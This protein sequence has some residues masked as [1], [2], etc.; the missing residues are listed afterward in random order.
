MLAA[1]SF[2]KRKIGRRFCP[3]EEEPRPKSF[4][5]VLSSEHSRASPARHTLCRVTGCSPSAGGGNKPYALDQLRGP[6]S[7]RPPSRAF[8]AAVFQGRTEC[9]SRAALLRRLTPLLSRR[10]VTAALR[11]FSPAHVRFGSSA[12]GRYASGGRAMS[13]APPK[14]DIRFTLRHVCL[15]PNS[16]HCRNAR[17]D[18]II[19]FKAAGVRGRCA[20]ASWKSASALR[21]AGL[22]PGPE[23][24]HWTPRAQ[25]RTGRQRGSG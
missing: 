8:E 23:K 7:A 20:V 15:V 21:T 12:T 1:L 5:R 16:E 18:W 2:L 19:A 11:D 17:Q 4:S 13:A 22:A 3:S 9:T 14:A 10:Q 6:H 24:S 25:R